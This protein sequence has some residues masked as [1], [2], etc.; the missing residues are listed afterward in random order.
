MAD[1]CGNEAPNASAKASLSIEP[2]LSPDELAD[3]GHLSNAPWWFR[4]LDVAWIAYFA[5]CV[6]RL[7]TGPN[8]HRGSSERN[9]ALILLGVCL[10]WILLV[11]LA[12]NLYARRSRT[13]GVR[14][15]ALYRHILFVP[16]VIVLKYIYMPPR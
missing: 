4:A 14:S 16:A 3:A 1:H 7:E 13:P 5:Y 11:S 6:W 12:Q 15:H 2:A 9:T 8:L 10:L